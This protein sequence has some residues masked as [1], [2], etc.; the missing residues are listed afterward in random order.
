[1]GQTYFGNPAVTWCASVSCECPDFPGSS[2]Q[3]CN[4]CG[5]DKESEDESQ[6]NIDAR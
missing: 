3:R 2:G 4:I 1:M 5:A 6:S